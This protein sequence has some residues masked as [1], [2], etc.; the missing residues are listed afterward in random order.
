MGVAS[1]MLKA[2]RQLKLEELRTIEPSIVV[3]DIRKHYQAERLVLVLGAGV[4]M[5]QG[6]PSWNTLLQALILE[7]ITSSLE[8]EK[9]ANPAL[10]AQVISKVFSPSPL[11]SARYL[12]SY[13]RQEYGD[14]PLAFTAAVR[15][16]LYKGLDPDA[17]TDLIREIREL[18][19]AAGKLPNL[20]SV[21]TYNFDDLLECSIQK[22]GLRVPFCSIY[23]T[24]MNPHDN[25][26][27]IFHVHGFL[28]RSAALDNSNQIALS[29]DIYHRQ[30][31]DAYTW[32][33]LVQIN[34]FKDASC[35][36]IGVS[37]TDPN[38][39]RLL[40]IA[41]LQRGDNEIHHYC[42]RKRYNIDE[43]KDAINGIIEKENVLQELTPDVLEE[44]AA[45][46]IRIMEGYETSDF[47]SFGVRAIWVDE[48]SEIP[49]L[50]RQI[51]E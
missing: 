31:K 2:L 26:L 32:S 12:S 28:P 35:L 11:I 29:E 8:E 45:N 21:I 3:S 10:I 27:A 17:E 22:L 6:I 20:D 47:E 24:G 4:S 46:L 34:K 43:V 33:N 37:F 42:F 1:L 36:F 19:V 41:R 39:R 18:C 5:D 30:Y 15:D 14:N 13:Y 49:E 44:S 40:D 16:I 9:N 23:E 50:L 7:S 51:R 25:E 38:L 48:Y